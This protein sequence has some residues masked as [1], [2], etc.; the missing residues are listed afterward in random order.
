MKLPLMF[1]VGCLAVVALSLSLPAAERLS[2]TISLLTAVGGVSGFLYAQHARDIQLFRELFREFNARYDTLN[3]RLNEIRNRE[4]GQPLK[5]TDHGVLFAYFNLCG[6]EY[7][8]ATA[9]YIDPRVWC[10]WHNG[11]CYFDRDPEIHN[12]WKDELRQDS[13]YGFALGCMPRNV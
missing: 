12:F 9:G 11:M 3:D 13:Y 5:E 8:Y 6:E 7:M 10:A 1:G 4:P 2:I